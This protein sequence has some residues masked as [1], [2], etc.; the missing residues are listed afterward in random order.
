MKKTKIFKKFF[1]PLAI[2]Y[3]KIYS[4]FYIPI[5]IFMSITRNGFLFNWSLLIDSFLF[6]LIFALAIIGLC[7]GWAVHLAFVYR[8]DGSYNQN[9]NNSK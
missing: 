6:T 2:G 5:A 7:A 8:D 1:F 3:T 9:Q 4:L